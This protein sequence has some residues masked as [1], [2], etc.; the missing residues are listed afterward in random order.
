M[1]TRIIII[2]VT[3]CGLIVTGCSSNVPEDFPRRLTV[4]SVNL[5]YEGKPV[6][7][8]SVALIPDASGVRFLVLGRTGSDGIATLETSINNY[9]KSGVPA[10]TYKGVVSHVPKVPSAWEPGEDQVPMSE[11][12]FETRNAKIKAE[13]VKARIVPQDWEMSGTT[14]LKIT[15]PEKGGSVT[16][17]ITDEKTFVQ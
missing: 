17:E 10:G 2:F 15:V 1:H 5:L 8:A 16:I 11:G 6:E 4:F 13:M 7:K 9:S 14:P 12:V 3:I